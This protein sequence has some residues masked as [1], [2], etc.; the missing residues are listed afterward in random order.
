MTMVPGWLV[1]R[2]PLV[3]NWNKALN[4]ASCWPSISRMEIKR[5]TKNAAAQKLRMGGRRCK[6]ISSRG[7]SCG[8]HTA[9]MMVRT[10]VTTASSSTS[11]FSLK[12]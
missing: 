7:P 3:K 5:I 6:N 9:P 2:I 1:S 4:Y 8:L 11:L 12:K 10:V